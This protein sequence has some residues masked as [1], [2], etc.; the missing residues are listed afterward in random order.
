MGSTSVFDI[1]T[2]GLSAGNDRMTE[3]GAVRMKN[4]EILDSF[5]TFVNPERPIP[6][7]ITELTGINDD[8]VKDAPSEK[9][10]LEAFYAFCGE[11]EPGAGGP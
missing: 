2:T 4:G 5:D 8:M 11:G 7:K 10:A 1:E 3:I 6:P 9:E